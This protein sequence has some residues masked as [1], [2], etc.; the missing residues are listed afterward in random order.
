MPSRLDHLS[1][2]MFKLAFLLAVAVYIWFQSLFVGTSH[3]VVGD[4]HLFGYSWIG[5]VTGF[6]FNIIPIGATWF[7]WRVKKDRLGAGLMLL[8]IPLFAAFVMPQLF[9]ERVEVSPG[10]LRH[11]REPAHSRFNADIAFHE[12]VSAV[13]VHNE[14]ALKGYAMTLKDGRTL[15]LPPN[16]VLTAAQETIAEQLRRRKIPVTIKM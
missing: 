5:L 13:E 3:T 14:N 9:M 8:A 6:G 4:R 16:T 2:Q 10:Y 1:T 15:E 12:I 7:L 11:R